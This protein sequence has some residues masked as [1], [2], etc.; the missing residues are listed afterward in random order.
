MDSPIV[1]GRPSVA[2]AGP[3]ALRPTGTASDAAVH[4]DGGDGEWC[5]L[6]A[7][8]VAGVRHRL[9][10]QAGQ[11][12]F[13]WACGPDRLAVAVTDGLGGVPGSAGASGRAATAA[14][15][16][17][18]A[19]GGSTVAQT[20]AGIDAGN[21]AAAQGGAT[22]IVLAVIPRDGDARVARVGDSTAFLIGV[23]GASWSE[24]F[25]PPVDDAVV[26]ATAALPAQV[27]DPEV[28]PFEL[29]AD[30]L[31]LLATDGVADP[32]RDGPTTVAPAL[33]AGM[34]CR[35]D[36]LHLAHLAGFS[37]QG[38]HDDRTVLLVW[39]S[40]PDRSR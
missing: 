9:S 35:P 14:V 40:S 26:T 18:L 23:G 2:A 24:L 6:R 20:Q 16:A 8:S 19:A 36:P 27:L 7:A 37:R 38:C 31:L 22:T 12:S 3:A 5:A 17:V 30:A 33:A 13:A 28:A 15:K 4:A 39:R 32:W 29:A 1:L 21:R 34:A 25:P 10:G 11:D